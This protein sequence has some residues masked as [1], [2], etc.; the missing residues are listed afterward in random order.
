[1]QLQF[2]PDSAWKTPV[3]GQR[4]CLKHV[5][6]YKRINLDNLCIWLVI[7]KRSK[8]VGIT[9]NFELKYTVLTLVHLLVLFY[10]YV[11]N[12]SGK[13]YLSLVVLCYKVAAVHAVGNFLMLTFFCAAI[14]HAL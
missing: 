3:D 12:I 6:F 5:E 1:M 14:G 2:H 8:H 4:R 7:K 13:C 9:K 10:K 11:S